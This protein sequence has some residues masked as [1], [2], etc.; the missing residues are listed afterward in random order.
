MGPSRGPKS[1][2]GNTGRDDDNVGIL[3][4]SLGSVIGGEEAGRL[5]LGRDVGEIGRDSGSV[6]DI[7]ER[8][9]VNKRGELEEKGEG[10]RDSLLGSVH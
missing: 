6:D 1:L 8:E 7:V 9:L 5:G 3:E 2:T 10:L 4:R